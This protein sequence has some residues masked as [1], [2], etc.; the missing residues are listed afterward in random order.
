MES[1]GEGV[2]ETFRFKMINTVAC[3]VLDSSVRLVGLRNNI[4][5]CRSHWRGRLR[6]KSLN[7]LEQ[8]EAQLLLRQ[9]ALW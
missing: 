5:L 4:A 6:Q 8:Q 7:H 3:F 9:L 1:K 2:G